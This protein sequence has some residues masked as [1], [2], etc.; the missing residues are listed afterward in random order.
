M[1]TLCGAIGA[2]ITNNCEKAP[3]AGLGRTVTLFNFDDVVGAT[4]DATDKL[5]VN[6]FD[7]KTGSRA[8]T[9]EVIGNSSNS[10][11]FE[12]VKKDWGGKMFTHTL[13]TVVTEKSTDNKANI[14]AMKDGRYIAVISNRSNN[15]DVKYEVL[16]LNS[17]LELSTMTWNS[18]ENDGIYQITLASE[19]GYEEPYIPATFQ[20]NG[21]GGNYD[22]AATA[23]AL[24]TYQTPAT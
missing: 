5:I 8:Y 4:Y 14:N 15:T 1:A 23:A 22:Q 16:G 7:L 17:G 21:S 3:S 9:W 18:A 20:V 19:E 10:A 24:T 12:A 2:N 6:A 13:N 11:A